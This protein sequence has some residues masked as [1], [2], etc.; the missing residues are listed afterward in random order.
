MT[1]I[2]YF[3]IALEISNIKKYYVSHNIT[4]LDAEIQ[5]LKNY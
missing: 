5:M 1:K 3:D 2:T 4:N